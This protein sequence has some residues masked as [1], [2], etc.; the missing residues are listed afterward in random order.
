MKRIV[1]LLLILFHVNFAM[2]QD[3]L[4]D[5]IHLKDV[6]VKAKQKK[7]II[8][9]SISGHPAYNSLQARMSKVVCLLDNLPSGKIENVTFYLNTGLPNLFKKKL[10][11]NYKDVWLGIIICEVDEKGKPGKTISENEVKF[12]V[13]A[14]HRG[15]ITVNLASL[16]LTSSKMFFGFTVLSLL[17]MTES[18]L[19]MRFC[20]DENARMYQFEKAYN[21]DEKNWYKV[22]NQSFKLRMKIQE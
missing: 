13:S 11:I 3:V 12:L 4:K 19:Y 7:K 2:S 21:S 14:D 22:G 17:S 1:I 18:N 16:N 10:Q 9:Y 15:A 20:E 6:T 5:T 8:N